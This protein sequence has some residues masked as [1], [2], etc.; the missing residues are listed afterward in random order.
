MDLWAYQNGAPIDF[1]RPGKPPDNANAESFNGRL[2]DEYLIVEEG[3]QHWTS[4]NS[5]GDQPPADDARRAVRDHK[6]IL[7]VARNSTSI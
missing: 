3:L 7:L 5:L 4:P 2:S 6:E 1:S